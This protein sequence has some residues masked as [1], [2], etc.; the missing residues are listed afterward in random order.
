MK[1]KAKVMVAKPAGKK[2]A[3]VVAASTKKMGGKKMCQS[4][5]FISFFEKPWRNLRLF[6]LAPDLLW[7]IKVIAI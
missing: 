7:F 3:V 1:T 4:F 5:R 6:Y 2:K